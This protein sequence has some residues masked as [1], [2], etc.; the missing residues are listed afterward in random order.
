MTIILQISDL[1]LL[2]QPEG[3]L[4]DVPTLE[5]LDL[6]LERA[7][8][9][10]PDPAHVVLTGDLSHEETLAGYELLKQALGSWA[11]RCLLIPGNHDNRA[12]LRQVF[13]QVPGSQ[14]EPIWFSRILEPWRLLGLDTHVPGEVWGFVSEP[15]LARLD[16]SLSQNPEQPTLIFLHHHPAPVGSPWVDHIGLR[17]AAA[18]TALLARYPGVRGLFCG[19][20]HQEFT[21][22]IGPTRFFSV[23]SAAV[24]F[25]PGTELMELDPLPPGFRIIELLEAG[26]FQ[27]RVVR[28]D[29][30]PFVPRQE[31]R[32]SHDK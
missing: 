20:I 29:E 11:E 6:V 26:Q 15:A 24:Q 16:E 3:R 7:R 4:K 9:E 27:T 12:A 1:H 19:H 30:L 28:L 5:S 10:V 31:E 2:S 14:D 23:P 32:R 25:K 18:L 17:N 8:Q 13:N 21:S 22:E